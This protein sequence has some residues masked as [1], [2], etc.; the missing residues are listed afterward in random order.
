MVTARMLFA[1][2]RLSFLFTLFLGTSCLAAGGAAASSCVWRV[3]G[4]GGEVLYLG[5]SV[6]AL[7]S[8]DY[9][10]PPAY[11][12][13][14]EASSRI[15]FE[16]DLKTLRASSERLLKIGQYRKGDSLK[17][18]VDSR[19][20][21]YVR[22]VFGLMKV[23]EE[24]LARCRPWMLTLMLQSPGLHGLSEELGLESFLS[25]RAQANAK[26]CSGL[27]TMAEHVEVF[28]GLSD[29][30]SEALLLLAFIPQ[31]TGLDGEGRLMAAWRRG[32]ADAL[33][34]ATHDSFREFPAFGERILDARNRKWLPQIETFLRSGQTYFVV[35][36]AAHLGGR[37]GVVN[38]LRERGWR[39]EQL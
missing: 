26:S 3:T 4:P 25:R 31:Q 38:L 1:G 14:F 32:D 29:R 12:R 6:H 39:L 34:S 7:K 19:T 13:A 24:K 2:R 8:G 27:E 37:G 28:S 20:Y 21:D 16:V 5:G 18:H 11:N 33:A 35:V 36:G 22:R 15:A 30:Q 17:K 23:P 9:P 10:L